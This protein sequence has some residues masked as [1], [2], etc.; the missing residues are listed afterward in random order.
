MNADSTDD[1]IQVTGHIS[2]EAQV[3]F[4]ADQSACL[5]LEIEPARGLPYLVIEPLGTDPSLQVAARAKARQLP[6][7]ALVTVYATHYTLQCDHGRQM[8]RLHGVN[9]VMCHQSHREAA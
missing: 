6:R 7:G 4:H 8:L 2:R 3:L 1:Q 9:G 5:A